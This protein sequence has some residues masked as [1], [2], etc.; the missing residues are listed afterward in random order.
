MTC[1]I[2]HPCIN[3]QQKRYNTLVLQQLHLPEFCCWD[4]STTALSLTIKVRLS[5][6]YSQTFEWFLKDIC[7][8]YI[9]NLLI[10]ILRNSLG[11]HQLGAFDPACDTGR[12][13]QGLTQWTHGH[14][15]LLIPVILWANY[16]I[17]TNY[18]TSSEPPEISR[19][20][21]ILTSYLSHSDSKHTENWSEAFKIIGWLTKE[22]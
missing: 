20:F 22:V 19:P 8:I 12:G 16:V 21:C 2:S 14:P 15:F 7:R 3:G 6:K 11:K 1:G 18:H 4:K 10:Y 5:I 9:L 13:S 17:L